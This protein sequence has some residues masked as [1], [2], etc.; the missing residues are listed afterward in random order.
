MS[1]ECPRMP[2]FWVRGFSDFLLIYFCPRPVLAFG[3]CRCL[4]LCVCVRVC[5]SV[6]QSRVCPRDNSSPVQARIKFGTQMQNSLVKVPIIIIIIIIFFFWGGGGDRYW[7]SRANSTWK[8]NFTSFWAC[9]DYNLSSVQAR[10]TK[11]GPK[12][13][14]VRSISLSIWELIDLDL[15]GQI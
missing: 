7:P 8:S 13:I 11:F 6:C 1:Q 9:P 15:Q 12:C 3:Y 10:V 4:R 2:H 5:L 14:L